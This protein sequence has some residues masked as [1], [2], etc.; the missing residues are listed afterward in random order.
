MGFVVLLA[1]A[2]YQYSSLDD[3]LLNTD[4]VL[5]AITQTTHRIQIEALCGRTSQ[6]RTQKIITKI[7]QLSQNLREYPLSANENNK[8]IDLEIS[9]VRLSRIFGHP[10]Q[11]EQFLPS[12][13]VKQIEAETI[14]ISRASKDLMLLIRKRLQL[15]QRRARFLISFFY[16]ILCLCSIGVVVFLSKSIISPVLRLSREIEEVQRGSRHNIAPAVTHNEIGNLIS[17]T[18]NTI[19]S[20]QL[21][22]QT[23]S[24]YSQIMELLVVTKTL[25]ELLHKA[26]K[27]ILSLDWFNIEDKG[28]VFLIN[29]AEPEMLVLKSS[30]NFSAEILQSCA[31]VP[32]GKCICG[33]TAVSRSLIHTCSVDQRHDIQYP[34]MLDHGHYCVPLLSNEELLGVMIFYLPAGRAAHPEEEEFLKGVANILSENI[35]RKRLEEQQALIS[36]AITQAA[37][38]V[39]ITDTKG[40]I[41]YANPFMTEMTGYT[42][43]EIISR[44]PRIFKSGKNDEQL[45]RRLWQTITSG[46]KWEGMLINKKKDG[47]L[48]EE[49]I[50]ITPVEN[51]NGEIAHFVAIK[52]DISKEKKLEQ[53]LIQS[54]KLEAIG[55]LA[56]GIAHD[57]NNI[58]TAIFG[59]T[60]LAKVHIPPES[61]VQDDL[62]QVLSGAK[63][64]RELVK[65][66]LTFSRKTESAIGPIRISL[67]I[68]EVIKMLRAS[69]PATIEIQDDIALDS[70]V[71]SADP[72]QVH[73][74]LMNLCTNAAQ[75]MEESGGKLS[76]SLTNVEITT[77]TSTYCNLQPGQYVK[78]EVND[79]GPGIPPEIKSRIFD[80]FFTTKEIGKGTGMGLSVVHGIVESYG[81]GLSVESTLQKGTKFSIYFPRIAAMEDAPK[82]A[83]VIPT[84][85]ER[86][87]FVDDEEVIVD[88]AGRMLEGL[89]YKITA[90]ADSEKALKVFQA[91]PEAFDLIISDQTMPHLTGYE[92]IL[93][94][95][96]TRPG[97]PTILCT[98]HSS[99][100]DSEKA[101]KHGITKFLL[102]PIKFEELAVSIRNVLDN[103]KQVSED[104][105]KAKT[106]G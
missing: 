38:G 68:K 65:H 64:A 74:I 18:R 78:L 50:L 4:A 39:V 102:K 63:R 22:C 11:A 105:G 54:Q 6:G 17:F 24:A 27:I 92:M 90:L 42:P 40:N 95:L 25:D 67:I 1:L 89:G 70:G 103:K 57:F 45:Y 82:Q 84:G 44:N 23:M 62:D 10:R 100:V 26:L 104:S 71:I 21:R 48:Y 14:K 91:Q 88:V 31:K 37:E 80:P 97:I 106:T 98:G 61:H 81:G 9:V 20:I 87:L 13:L 36:T 52:Q 8:L 33:R 94:I 77:D 43:E 60:Q 19:S 101:V 75:A 49:K 2:F 73:Q 34:G 99:Q 32:F 5:D 30:V 53:Q 41:Q 59:F 58:L 3:R 46:E 76:I 83:A 12:P 16:F 7:N 56:G 66:I 47:S 85:N 79:T 28:A 72:T 86:I 93:K 15:E 96:K 35:T 51:E 55:T 69:I 29:S